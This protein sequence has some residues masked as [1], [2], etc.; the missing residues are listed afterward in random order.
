M[1]A[2][3]E[4]LT[5]DEAAPAAPAESLPDWLAQAEPSAAQEVPE[6]SAEPSTPVPDWLAQA[7]GLGGEEPAAEQVAPPEP[8][9]TG[10]T[11]AWLALAEAEFA[12]AESEAEP[13]PETPAAQ[14]EWLQDD[15]DA[16]PPEA[17]PEDSGVSYDAW[18]AEQ[19]E[20]E[21]EPTQEEQLAEE[22]PDW[23]EGIAAEDAVPQGESD[24]A[25]ATGSEPEFRPDWYLGLE[26]QDTSAAPDWFDQS[27]L[28]A[29]MLTSTPELPTAPPEPEPTPEPPPSSEAAAAPEPA[30]DVPDWFAEIEGA[31]AEAA[32]A[33]AE[34]SAEVPDTGDLPDWFADLQPEE[35]ISPASD[36]ALDL[37]ALFGEAP[38][39]ADAPAQPGPA[40]EIDF[41]TLMGE[42]VLEA[43]PASDSAPDW[44]ADFDAPA[45]PAAPPDLEPGDAPDWLDA[46][47]PGDMAAAEEQAAEESI[48]AGDADFM[49]VIEQELGDYDALEGLDLGSGSAMV[50]EADARFD[51]ESLLA[52]QARDLP[53]ADE[54]D[55]APQATG[56]SLS[57]ATREL[58]E[59]LLDAQPGQ[60]GGI[61]FSA[62]SLAL[63]QP[64]APLEELSD[65]LR[66]LRERSAEV[67]QIE[68]VP[69]A[70]PALS[71]HDV[72]ADLPG[73]LA[74]TDLLTSGGGPEVAMDL[75][76]SDAQQARVRR[77]ELML[78][79][80]VVPSA[81]ALD[82]E[83]QPIPVD[84]A[85][86]IA[87][88][89]E[90]ARRAR[91]RSRRKPDRFLVSLL[92]LAALVIPFF[93]NVSTLI[94][95]PPTAL[96]PAVQGTLDASI[97][98]LRPGERV[99]VGFEYGPTAAGE[100]DALAEPLLTHIL[101]RGALPVIVSTNP[102]GI[103]HAR[104]VLARLGRDPFLLAHL[105]RPANDPL[106]AGD[107]Y[108][109]LPYLSGGVV[110]LRALA[111]IGTPG[112]LDTGLFAVD[113]NGD[114][115]ELRIRSLATSFKLG[116]VLAE[117]GD[118]VRLWVE[119]IGATNL[120]LGA[121]V[122]AAAEPLARPYFQSGQLV[123]ILA[124]YRD[125]Y[126][127]DSVLL[128]S[129]PPVYALED[130]PVGTPEEATPEA[131]PTA[132]TSAGDTG[133]GLAFQPTPDALA[134]AADRGALVQ[135]LVTNT[136]APSDTPAPSA[137]PRA[138]VT[139]ARTAT[140]SQ[141]GTPVA[142]ERVFVTAT[143][144]P[145]AGVVSGQAQP[146]Q[147]DRTY[148]AERWY[149][150]TLGALAAAA[151]IGLGAVVNILR[152]LRRRRNS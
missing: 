74:P 21:R 14:P 30:S 119:Q 139:P 127:Y 19:T 114:P 29:D 16:L 146:L 12:S 10:G 143:P 56:E 51:F 122:T 60:S 131:T 128:A 89:R 69:M 147:P 72:L 48:A 61:G 142:T 104:D 55:A 108:V 123:G 5:E 118:N 134:T 151:L 50:S 107:D 27:M 93:A 152:G 39:V 91:A 62:V 96:D 24:A 35:P 9:T 66:A 41:E 85:R 82:A 65:R 53:P 130:L 76:V 38:A 83:G 150:L 31:P 1:A 117:Q 90:T 88:I 110:G 57:D 73:A 42:A 135:G 86:E 103:L 70:G 98:A 99:L 37:D 148:R 136:P 84:Q 4:F 45:P 77:L 141:A 92:L 63:R 13:E 46:I 11:P 17:P 68:S 109:L 137:T 129:L 145:A 140:G 22:V 7:E 100:L 78:G 112:A 138:T 115:T 95:L 81:P 121:G 67:A 64:E 6:E 26:E 32:E 36:D 132:D 75:T 20:K 47:A 124:G 116:L 40:D 106:R 33:P 102:A 43:T 133:S 59:W 113:L 120:A 44:I 125:A 23:F 126:T 97:Q 54:D 80:D 28:S 111:A 144:A 149:S 71:S 15:Q 94:T 2:A 58:P 34:T 101:L 8:G 79:L 18:M 49:S 25:P 52:D 105:D 3:D 87:R